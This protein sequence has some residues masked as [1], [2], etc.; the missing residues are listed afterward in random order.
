MAKART[1]S[2]LPALVALFAAASADTG[3]ADLPSRSCPALAAAPLIYG[4]IPNSLG[5]RTWPERQMDEVRLGIGG[6]THEDA[7]ALTTFALLSLHTPQTTNAYAL[8]M[9][10]APRAT[11]ARDGQALRDR[12]AAS[13]EEG[14]IV[15]AFEAM[16][17]SPE[18]LVEA[19]EMPAAALAL[20]DAIEDLYGL[21]FRQRR[22]DREG[23][24]SALEDLRVDPDAREPGD[25]RY[26][27]PKETERDPNLVIFAKRVVRSV[28]KIMLGIAIG[29]LIWGF[30]RN[31]T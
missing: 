30:V 27:K 12:P 29:I 16:G 4:L 13:F 1:W 20:A 18:D 17:L 26:R 14:R 2:I 28:Y 25:P 8:E 19:P 10:E 11:P 9:M 21:V 31:T 22:R 23:G 6:E 24:R 7:S 5:A 15:G 3:S